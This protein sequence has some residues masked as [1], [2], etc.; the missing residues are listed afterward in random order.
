MTLPTRRAPL[1][2]ETHVAILQIFV[3][4]SFA[5]F[6]LILRVSIN[7]GPQVLAILLLYSLLYFTLLKWIPVRCQ[8]SGCTS[9][10]KWTMRRLSFFRTKVTYQCNSCKRT[11]ATEIFYPNMT[12]DDSD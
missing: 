5:I 1:N 4:L 11:F 7:S 8:R 10:M 3:L 2:T 6:P 9:T 12:V